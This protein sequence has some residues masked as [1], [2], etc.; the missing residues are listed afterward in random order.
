MPNQKDRAVKTLLV[1]FTLYVSTVSALAQ[2]P[3]GCNKFKWPLE[4]ERA[5]LT[6]SDLPK[7]TSGSRATCPLP[8]ATEVTLLPFDAAELP[9]VPE[10]T[11]KSNNP[12]AGFIEASAPAQGGTYKITLSSEGWID[13]LQA[14]NRLKSI[15]ATGATGCEGV[16]KSVKFD[17][18]KAP[19][20]VQF[21][22]IKTSR[23]PS[24][25]AASDLLALPPRSGGEG[26]RISRQ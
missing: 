2:E 16:R 18:A 20:T 17:L 13:V 24:R 26:Q 22:G 12:F 21:S 7:L 25:S 10:R 8:F 15:A 14:G 11:P 1:L 3:V 9:V 6:G 23:S 19:F 5:T 4:K